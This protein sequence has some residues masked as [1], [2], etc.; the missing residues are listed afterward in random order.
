ML[1]IAGPIDSAMDQEPGESIPWARMARMEL[2]SVGRSSVSSQVDRL[3][4]ISGVQDLT[5]RLQWMKENEETKRFRPT[6]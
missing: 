3:V 2:S 5:T 1:W 6:G 4:L